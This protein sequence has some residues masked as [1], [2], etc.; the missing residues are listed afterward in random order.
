MLVKIEGLFWIF[1]IPLA[2]CHP[3]R[4]RC[5]SYGRYGR[6]LALLDKPPRPSEADEAQGY[7]RSAPSVMLRSSGGWHSPSRI[8]NIQNNP[9]IFIEIRW[10]HISRLSHIK[11]DIG[12]KRNLKKSWHGSPKEKFTTL[13]MSELC[14]YILFSDRKAAHGTIRNI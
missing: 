11:E 8:P 1:G 3:R 14:T 7:A 5:Q 6:A 2:K 12:R 4:L 9:S 10:F 13:F